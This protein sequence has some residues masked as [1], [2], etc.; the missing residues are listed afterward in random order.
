MLHYKDRLF[1]D[2]D[3]RQNVEDVAR[4]SYLIIWILM[5]IPALEKWY[6]HIETVSGIHYFSAPAARSHPSWPQPPVYLEVMFVWYTWRGEVSPQDMCRTYM[7]RWYLYG[8]KFSEISR[9]TDFVTD[10]Y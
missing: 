6:L 3:S 5:E 7:I 10:V 9:F 1:R 8:I 2:N 4:L